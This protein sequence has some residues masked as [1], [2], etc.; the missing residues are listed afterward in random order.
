MQREHKIW[1]SGIHEWNQFLDAK[2]IQGL[3]AARKQTH[4]SLLRHAHAQLQEDNAQW[5]ASIMPQNQHWRL[6][7]KF[8]QDACFLDIETDGYYGSIT[9]IGV[10]DGTEAHTFVRGVNLDKELLGNLLSQYKLMLTFNGSSFDLPVIQRYFN[11][12]PTMPHIDLRHV[13]SKIGLTGGLKKIE[14]DLGIQ[15]PEELQGITGMEAVQLWQD[16]KRTQDQNYLDLLVKYN[17]E[18]IVNLPRIAETVIPQLWKHVRNDE[19]QMKGDEIDRQS[20]RE[21]LKKK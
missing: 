17:T 18:D 19:Q 8:K 11:L 7:D 15:R 6:Y 16:F 4:D 10:Y 9:V 1:Q 5:F 12:K 3:S 21:H 2:K 13:C 20:L 14:G